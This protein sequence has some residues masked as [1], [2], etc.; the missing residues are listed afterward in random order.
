SSR[1]RHTRSKRDWSSDVCSSDLHGALTETFEEL[2]HSLTF[3]FNTLLADKHTDD[4]LR[5]Y[6]SWIS[7]RNLSNEIDDETVDILVNSVTGSYDQVHRFYELKRFILC[8]D[9][10]YD[11]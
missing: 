2:S 11:Y 7:S 6:S 10:F 5:S 1:R 8:Y 4:R 3:I 9:Q